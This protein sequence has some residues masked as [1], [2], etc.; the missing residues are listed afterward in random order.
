MSRIAPQASPED[1]V[2]DRAAQVAGLNDKVRRCQDPQA[3]IV[4]TCGVAELLAQHATDEPVRTAHLILNQALLMRAI[5]EAEIA[6][7][8][9]PHDERDF[10]GVTFLEQ[11][12]FWKVD[13]YAADGEFAY[14][15]KAPWDPTMTTRV[16][17]IMLASE[18]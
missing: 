15:S 2:Q 4:M 3:R 9:D 13:Y 10:G 5:A 12:L 17:T 18:Y 6:P 14:G 16:L 8:D 1:R 7:G 11:R